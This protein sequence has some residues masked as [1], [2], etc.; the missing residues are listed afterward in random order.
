[1][2]SLIEP[3][4]VLVA[5]HDFGGL[6]LLAPLLRVWQGDSRFA[7]A[8]VSTPAVRRE[9]SA[10]VP[11]LRFPGW[12]GGVTEHLCANTDELDAYL[13][14]SLDPHEWDVL[15]CATSRV[16]LL[17]KHLIRVA[18][19]RGLH[20]IAFCDMWW[21]YEERF[22]D[23]RQ[24]SAP[25]TLW[26]LDERMRDEI[27][28]IPWPDPPAVEV[29][30]SPRFQ[31]LAD[32]RSGTVSSDGAIRFI[33]E[34]ASSKFPWSGVDEFELAEALVTTARAAGIKT[35]IVVRTHPEDPIE[36]W[37]RWA[38]R[39]R[40]QGVELDAMPLTPCIADTARAVGISSMLLPEMAVCGVPAAS[41]QWPGTDPAYYCLP[42]EEF[43]ITR[44][45]SVEAL[46]RWLTASPADGA[47]RV[48]ASVHASAIERI[49]ARLV[50]ERA[51]SARG[52]AGAREDEGL[53]MSEPVREP[54]TAAAVARV[55]ARATPA[56][57][58]RPPTL[59]GPS[60]RLVPFSPRHITERYVRWL[61]DPAVVR[62]S[63]LRHRHHTRQSCR[64][65][66]RS[67]RDGGHGFWAIVADVPP[68]RHVG[69]V[70]AYIDRP[71]RLA[72]VS[73]LI[74]ERAV[75]GRGLG[76]T[77]WSLVVDWLLGAGGMRKVV[78]GTMTANKAM[79]RVMERSG[80][81]IE[82]RYARHLLLD[83]EE[84]DVVS[85]ARFKEGDG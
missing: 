32:L 54:R 81:A 22:R 38:W 24:W 58:L 8:F 9:M 5:G 36:Q 76:S 28:E 23:G 66:L 62:F 16:S 1:M 51:A 40:D 43:G 73:I 85:G 11:G 10:R 56:G 65:Y 82:A 34:P 61:N 59:S 14:L 3:T 30:G 79:L 49:T 46:E 44:V 70:A 37:R 71:N 21:A 84:I 29:V 18:R 57:T 63:E 69:N 27:A 78:A 77:A 39:L 33:S 55:K 67:M 7:A 35:R 31:E 19:K 26:V 4:R 53:E 13:E 60:V 15:L 2:K 47:T 20:A 75:W 17:E 42:F 50:G 48:R 25:D 52:G 83:G 12:A 64:R 45:T 68:V 72:E 74:G 80:M 41:L 6:N